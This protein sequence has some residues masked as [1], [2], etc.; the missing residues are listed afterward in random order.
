MKSAE[1]AFQTTN[2]Q[3]KNEH[4]SITLNSYIHSN[5]DLTKHYQ[6]YAEVPVKHT[7]E[8]NEK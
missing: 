6:V 5:T 1:S 4:K 8:N 3:H 2:A 7:G